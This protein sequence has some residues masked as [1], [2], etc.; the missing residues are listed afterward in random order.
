MRIAV[1]A[2]APATP[3]PFE[4]N[5]SLE[6]STDTPNQAISCQ[7]CAKRIA[8]LARPV[9]ASD[10]LRVDGQ[11]NVLGAVQDADP[12]LDEQLHVLPA[13]KWL[14]QLSSS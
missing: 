10:V 14:C 11:R 4:A 9:E 13:L 5:R 8:F 2:G 7:S 1:K 3:L 12:V 6:D